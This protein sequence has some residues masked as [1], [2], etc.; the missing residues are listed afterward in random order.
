MLCKNRLKSDKIKENQGIKIHE[1]VFFRWRAQGTGG[2]RHGRVQ[3]TAKRG[4][5]KA[6]QK[7]A[8]TRHRPYV[9]LVGLILYLTIAKIKY[10]ENIIVSIA[11]RNKRI[12]KNYL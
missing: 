3:G 10:L 7:R 12:R 11:N 2:T 5:H 1:F 4:G 8:G 6:P 9:I